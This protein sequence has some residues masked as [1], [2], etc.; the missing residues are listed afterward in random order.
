[1]CAGSTGIDLTTGCHFSALAPVVPVPMSPHS[2]KW[3]P[4]M[5]LAAVTAGCS[6]R[7]STPVPPARPAEEPEAKARYLQALVD[8]QPHHWR[9]YVRLASV[10]TASGQNREALDALRSAVEVAPPSG[11]LYATLADTAEAAGHLDWALHGWQSAVQHEPM[12][13]LG[14]VRLARL[15]LRLGWVSAAEGVL[16]RGSARLPHSLRIL[17]ERASVAAAGGSPEDAARIARELIARFPA[18]PFGYSALADAHAA[19]GRWREAVLTGQKAAARAPDPFPFQLRLAEYEIER[20]DA[21]NPTRALAILES[22]G[23]G[24]RRNEPQ[25]R[26]VRGRALK[27]AGRAAEAA[28]EFE[29]VCAQEPTHVGALREL[30]RIYTERGETARARALITED[31]A[32]A[33]LV[34]ERSEV[35]RR[36]NQQPGSDGPHLEMAEL[37]VR[38]GDLPE[39]ALEFGIARMLN[40]RNKS[41]AQGLAEALRKQGRD[42][43]SVAPR[44]RPGA[45]G[46]PARGSS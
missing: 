23:Q 14:W 39:A 35:L 12:L 33:S 20:T 7:S 43:D 36:L 32:Q 11:G 6:A 19:R 30:A 31:L 8:R 41:A 29:A 21:P 9:A 45:A 4:L 16:A 38:A 24:E 18:S 13:T 42:L 46:A 10:R 40:P 37:H 1:L 22:G 5:L 17:R 25:V 3:L 27:S 34:R 15:Y 26:Y 2:H 28:A 44:L